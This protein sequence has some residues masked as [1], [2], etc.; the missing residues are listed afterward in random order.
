VRDGQTSPH[1][2]R[3][4][5]SRSTCPPI[6]PP[7]HVNSFVLGPAVINTHTLTAPLICADLADGLAHRVLLATVALLPSPAV[8]PVSTFLVMDAAV[9]R[10]ALPTAMTT[11][12]A[13]GANATFQGMRRRIA[14]QSRGFQA[15][16]GGEEEWCVRRGGAAAGGRKEEA[17]AGGA[18]VDCQG[19]GGRWWMFVY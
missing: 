15:E 18:A 19:A 2:P 17:G 14:E 8:V 16:G 1:R 9:A 10:A 6:S 7:P 3:L 4:V 12:I 5:V 11:V 13:P